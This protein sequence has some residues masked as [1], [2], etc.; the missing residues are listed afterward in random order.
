MGPLDLLIHLANFCLPAVVLASVLASGSRFLG[1]KSPK[2]RTA[3]S[4]FA[5]NMVVGV[6][7]LVAGL[8][9]FG[10]DGKMLTYLALV[11]VVATSQWALG[12]LWK[13]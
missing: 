1:K 2:A 5:I 7:V 11:L 13:G 3:W 4:L 9:V 10:R 12:R 6:A 8:V